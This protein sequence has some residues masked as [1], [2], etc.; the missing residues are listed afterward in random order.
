M[1]EVTEKEMKL[2]RCASSDLLEIRKPNFFFFQQHIFLLLQNPT[3]DHLNMILS[4][5]MKSFFIMCHKPITGVKNIFFFQTHTS[6]P[7]YHKIQ[8]M[9]IWIWFYPNP[10]SH[11]L[12]RVTSP[13]LVLFPEMERGLIRRSE[14]FWFPLS[15]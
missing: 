8:H 9:T 11:F 3:L 5:F 13:P 10:L 15:L 6:F 2:C 12:S 14:E 1:K 7:L 4:K